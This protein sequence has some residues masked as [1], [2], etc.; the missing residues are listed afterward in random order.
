MKNR[1][2]IKD[3]SVVYILSSN[4]ISTEWL[5]TWGSALASGCDLST[6][7]SPKVART[8]SR[9]WKWLSNGI[10]C[11]ISFYSGQLMRLNAKLTSTRQ[12][13]V[14]S[15]AER[16]WLKSLIFIKRATLVRWRAD[17]TFEDVN[18]SKCAQSMENREKKVWTNVNVCKLTISIDRAYIDA[19]K[20]EL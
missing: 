5:L 8:I 9:G 11:V 7:L 14:K 10:N 16:M 4:K 1:L 15:G 20:D 2:A 18:S 6:D 19:V 3:F 13:S 12:W 17:I